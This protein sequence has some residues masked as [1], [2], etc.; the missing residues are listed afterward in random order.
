MQGELWQKHS[1]W[2]V[3]GNPGSSEKKLQGISVWLWGGAGDNLSADRE[4]VMRRVGLSDS[5]GE[6]VK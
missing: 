4:S 5:R 2:K 3:W 1:H 6:S